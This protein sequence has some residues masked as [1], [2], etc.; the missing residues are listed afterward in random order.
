[1]LHDQLV[2]HVNGH[3]VRERLLLETDLTLDKTI[4]IATQMEE[5]GEQGKIISN[6]TSVHVQGIQAM[7]VPAVDRYKRKLSVNPLSVHSKSCAT[8]LTRACYL[9]GSTKHLTNDSRCPADSVNCVYEK[10]FKQDSL[11]PPSVKLATY[12]RD[13]IPVLGCLPVIVTKDDIDCNTSV[14]IV[15]CGT[16]LLGMDLINGLHLRFEGSSIQ[17]EPAQSSVPIMCLSA[18]VKLRW[19]PLL[20]R[21]A[22]SNELQCLLD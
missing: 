21:N 5:A 1:M 8:F 15:E 17:S 12:S 9:F 14:F 11:L 10:H 7:S 19:L 22:V 20:V 18:S 16:A 2:E 4:T 3:R 13:P 6:Q